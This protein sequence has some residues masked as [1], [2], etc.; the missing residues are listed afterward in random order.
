MLWNCPHCQAPITQKTVKSVKLEAEGGRR[1]MQ[2]PSC[3]KEVEYNIHPA[4]YWQLVIPLVGLLA[5]WWAS[6]NGSNQAT[7][8][9]A[10]IIGGGLVAT[11]VVKKRVLGAWQRFRAPASRA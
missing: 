6:K 5:L 8:A 1:A 9:A 3:D 4:E 11:M 10:V 2:C 7:M